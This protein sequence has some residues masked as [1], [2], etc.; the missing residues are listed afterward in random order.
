MKK[1]LIFAPIM[2]LIG[3]LLFLLRATGMT[4]H[5]IISIVGVVT[6]VAYA[7]ATKKEWKLPALEVLMRVCY[8]I[9][10]ITGIVMMKVHG[11]AALGIAHKAGAALFAVLLVAL[12]VHKLTGK[13]AK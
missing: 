3:M 8:G 7:I 1:D 12:L 13:K 4:V 11:I 10:L 5:I 2:L 6:L 9:A